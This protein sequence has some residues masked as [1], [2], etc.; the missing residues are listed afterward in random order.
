[1]YSVSPELQGAKDEYRIAMVQANW[2][3]VYTAIAI[4]DINNGNTD[5]AITSMN[6]AAEALKSCNKHTMTA[7]SLLDE[8]RSNKK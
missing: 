3:A 7:N 1:M 2:C 6:Q 4:N 5:D 8:Y